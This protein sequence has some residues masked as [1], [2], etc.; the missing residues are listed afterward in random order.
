MSTRWLL[1]TSRLSAMDIV[2]DPHLSVDDKRSLLMNRAYAEYLLDRRG[3]AAA[4]TPWSMLREIEQALIA[5]EGG[6]SAGERPAAA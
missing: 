3:G 6:A 2:R 5:L 1:L 4:P